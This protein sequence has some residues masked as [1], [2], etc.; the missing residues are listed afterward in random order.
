MN[1]TGYKKIAILVVPAMAILAVLVLSTQLSAAR[2]TG[3]FGIGT[4]GWMYD[5][6][7]PDM[8]AWN[9]PERGMRARLG[10][11]DAG[12]NIL[13]LV[14]R[15][16]L[17]DEQAEKIK[18]TIK[19]NQ[20]KIQTAQKAVAEARKALNEAVAKGAD[21]TAIREAATAVGKAL[22]DAAVLRVNTKTAVEK[23]LTDE[24]RAKLEE[25]RKEMKEQ[26]TNR[27]G[28]VQRPGLRGRFQQQGLRE[29]VWPGGPP[30]GYGRGP[31][32]YGPGRAGPMRRGWMREPFDQGQG[33]GQPW[34][35]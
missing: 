12:P 29:D 25:L 3:R 19:A 4:G 9:I 22:G 8:G 16:D 18:E 34:G 5:R 35:W 2:G 30:Y 15:L 6:P 33:R 11:N 17:T 28:E 23:I 20:E 24:Q 7:G 21:E 31:M 26:L 10:Q 27:A 1:T 32:F 13:R 14:R